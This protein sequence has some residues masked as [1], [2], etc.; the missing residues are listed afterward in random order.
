MAEPQEI[1]GRLPHTWPLFFARHGAFTPVQQQAILPILDGQDTLVVAAT[2][3]GKTEAVVAP[4]LERQWPRLNQ[5]EAPGLAI[6][7][8]CPTRAL[9]RDLYER[10]QPALAGTRVTVVMKTGDT[11]P[12]DGR[13]PPSLLLTTPESVDSLL[14]RS[15]RL[16]A[17]L[18]AIVLDEVHLFDNTPRG[19][20]TRCL[21]ARLERIRQYAHPGM[22]SAQRVALSATVPDPAGIAGRYLQGGAA[23]VLVPGDRQIVAE[24]WPLYDLQ[25]LVAAL[26]RRANRKS[27]LF[28]NTRAEVEQAAAY[29][30]RHLSYHAELY[31]HYS[32]LDPQMRREVEERFAAA[33]VAVC[34]STSTLELGIDI[35]SVDEVVLLGAPPTL[36]AFRQRIGRG[37]RRTG[38]MRVLCL[39]K[40]PGEW[41][42]FEALLHLARQAQ[43]G[44]GEVTAGESYG[45]RPSVLVQQIFSLIKQSPTG[46]VRLADVQRIAPPDVGEKTIRQLVSQL[47]FAGYVRPGRLG[48]WRPDEKLQELID[49]HEIYSNIGADPLG[50]TA[51]DAYSGAT[52]GQVERFYEKGQVVLFGGRT[53][54]VVWQEGYRFGLAPAPGKKV[55]EI[56]RFPSAAAA[57]PFAVTQA[58]ARSLG[59]A[60]GRI[61]TL[62]A[63]EDLLLYHFWGTIWGELLAKLLL[64]HSFVAEPVN[65]YC[66]LLRPRLDQL[67]PWDEALSRPV[68]ANA[69]VALADRLELGR[70]HHLLPANVA[71]AAALR[72]LNVVAWERVYRESKLVP[73]AREIE[74]QLRLLVQG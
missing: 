31:V 68:V 26:A 4:L 21:L 47:V 66:L 10:L 15:P 65:E 6:L 38:Q 41:A 27:L 24:I 40:S 73:A 54:E 29:L 43:Q 60:P 7:Y 49:R 71:A 56:L 55:D 44:E 18:Q 36:T 22:H 3:S 53:L 70:F 39:P 51:V 2:A 46:S 35:G 30:R 48:E 20:H 45:F 17:G 72:Q 32:N 28:C 13:R 34:V 42:R 25:A 62:P 67:P 58:V 57:I 74:T 69:A 37:S 5:P 14:T 8:I 23:I 61:V 12:V 63:E 33:A 52:I 1:K 19:D 16:F 50:A 59:L 64:A 9:V 11:G